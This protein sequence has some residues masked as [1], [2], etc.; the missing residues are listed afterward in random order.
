[1]P[2]CSAFL[3]SRKLVTAVSEE[4][5]S[6]PIA[7]TIMAFRNLCQLER[8]VATLFR[9]HN[10][11]CIHV[12]ARAQNARRIHRSV[13][14][15]LKCY[16]A[17]GFT[18]VFLSSRLVD[19]E[20]ATF[21]SLE[22]DLVCM[23][24]LL[25]VA[26][27][28]TY[29]YPWKYLINLNSHEFPLKTNLEMVRLLRRLDGANVVEGYAMPEQMYVERFGL[30]ASPFPAHSGIRI[31][32]GEPRVF[33]CRGFVEALFTS[34]PARALL[35]WLNDS[36]VRAP[37]EAFFNTLNHNSAA[38]PLPGA[39]TRYGVG[40]TPYSF[41]RHILWKAPSNEKHCASR[42]WQR[43][44]CIFGVRDLPELTNVS[45]AAF[46]LNKLYWDVEPLTFDC[47][48][49]WL[50]AKVERERIEGPP[51]AFSRLLTELDN[52]HMNTS[53]VPCPPFQ[54]IR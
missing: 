17:S 53:H 27:T 36:A 18:N 14:N 34:A 33:A 54:P 22:A 45:L 39:F 24:D 13:Q 26:K 37:D 20:W 44:I 41:V 31:M 32:K 19:V 50:K 8:L 30:K 40:P 12:D 3:S 25:A 29:R 52:F 28:N 49:Y 46:F 42:R 11:I 23:Q 38:L 1:M 47:L 5:A 7:F 9:P 6:F 10:P 21:S 35:A 4:E 43:G 15:L 51:L 48:E 2:N 16:H